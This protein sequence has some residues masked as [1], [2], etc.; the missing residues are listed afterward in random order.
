MIMEHVFKV[1]HRKCI[2]HES[3][4]IIQLIKLQFCGLSIAQN[5]GNSFIQIQHAQMRLKD[6][7]K[8]FYSHSLQ[9]C[10]NEP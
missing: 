6:I 10:K 3:Q 9:K 5:F 8:H 1:I 4:L 7:P 2:K